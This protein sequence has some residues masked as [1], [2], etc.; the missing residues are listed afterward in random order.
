MLLV[1]FFKLFKP[2]V[3]TKQTFEI[4]IA[5][6][7]AKLLIE[8][9][10]VKMRF[11]YSE[12]KCIH[13]T[14]LSRLVYES[15][16]AKILC[17]HVFLLIFF[18]FFFF[19]FF[20]AVLHFSLVFLFKSILMFCCFFCK[21]NFGWKYFPSLKSIQVQVNHVIQFSQECNRKTWL[22]RTV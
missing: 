19:S 10:P 20:R 3:D 16:E 22:V 15:V 6:I 21:N 8:H 2:P 7:K 11:H 17:Y 4:K 14:T 9:E 1:L 13:S 18:Q 12:S 5:T